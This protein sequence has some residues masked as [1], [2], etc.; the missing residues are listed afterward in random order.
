MVSVI[1]PVY[2]NEKYIGRCLESLLCQDYR[3]YE[4]IV[5]NDGST[6]G[7]V[8]KIKAINSDRDRKS[9]V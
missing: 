3:D 5:V 2:N 1:V 9:V 8:E 4:I 7:S 6:D